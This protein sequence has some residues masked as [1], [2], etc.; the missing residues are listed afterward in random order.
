[1]Y[2]GT[3]V[4]YYVGAHELNVFWG[5]WTLKEDLD[6]LTLFTAFTVHKYRWAFYCDLYR[7]VFN[8][9]LIFNRYN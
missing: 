5:R 2:V 8:D 9:I 7:V 6:G 3:F 4:I 1:M